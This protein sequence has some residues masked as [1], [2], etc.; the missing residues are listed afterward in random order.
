[1]EDVINYLAQE[2]ER[3]DTEREKC[4]KDNLGGLATVYEHR[5]ELFKQAV[6]ILLK[7]G[8]NS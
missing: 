3:C 1:M 2:Y 4:M 7:A 5:M 6:S 8:N